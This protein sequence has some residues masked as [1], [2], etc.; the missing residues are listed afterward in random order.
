MDEG[1]IECTTDHLAAP[2]R[3]KGPVDFAIAPGL[4]K[5]NLLDF[6][7]DALLEFGRTLRVFPT[8]ETLVVDRELS[9]DLG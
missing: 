8:V 2:I 5:R 4:S 1:G 3:V 9:H 6:V 7:P